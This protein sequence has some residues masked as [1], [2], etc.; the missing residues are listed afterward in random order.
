MS[1][2]SSGSEANAIKDVSRQVQQMYERLSDEERSTIRLARRANYAVIAVTAV[3]MAI[4][5]GFLYF[6]IGSYNST[7]EEANS[8]REETRR[9]IIEVKNE[10]NEQLKAVKAESEQKQQDLKKVVD[11]QVKVFS[12]EATALTRVKTEAQHALESITTSVENIR[13]KD[14]KDLGAAVR[15][16]EEKLET[17]S[18]LLDGASTRHSG[19]AKDQSELA[20]QIKDF[21]ENEIKNLTSKLN[22]FEKKR[23]LVEGLLTKQKDLESRI[24]ALE[25]K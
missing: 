17:L 14:L 18:K 9:Q 22:D 21:S 13:E 10:L 4:S 16:A 7:R 12:K 3:G 15:K 19:L 8:T 23:L 6:A 1:S 20:K 11:D 5:F 2:T 25:Q 24:I